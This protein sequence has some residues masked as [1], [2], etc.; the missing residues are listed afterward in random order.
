MAEVTFATPAVQRHVIGDLVIRLFVV[1]GA[2]GST[3]HTGAQGILWVA[4]QPFTQAGT[5]S[6]ITGISVSGNVVTL[7]SSSTMVTEVIQVISK[8]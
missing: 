1:G 5:A 2:S 8:A 3:I 6:L 7:T 4:N